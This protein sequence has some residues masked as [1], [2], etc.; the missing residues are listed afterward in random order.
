MRLI[1]H[2]LRAEGRSS[3]TAYLLDPEISYGV[4]KK[5][6]CVIVCPGGG[7]CIR[8][9]KE[10]EPIAARLLGAGYHAVVL[11]YPVLFAARPSTPG[12]QPQIDEGVA[13]PIQ[14][15]DLM[16]TMQWVHEHADR[17]EIDAD[18]IY[19][20]GFSAGAHLAGSLA[21]QWDDSQA[22]S[23]L[24]VPNPCELRPR[25]VVMCYPMVDARDVLF[26]DPETLPD[27][28]RW[29]LPYFLRAMTGSDVPDEAA[30]DRLDL[31][32]HVRA[33]MPRLFLWGTGEDELVSPQSL[34]RF[35]AR[36]SQLGVSV[37]FHLFSQGPHG[38]ALAEQA[39]AAVP[40]DAREDVAA[41]V[42][43]MLRWLDQDRS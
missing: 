21:E 18:R 7:Y 8:A 43:L 4:T 32:A 31:I 16:R 25:G 24:D 5:R 20:M 39:S 11:R 19:V 9:T 29:Q 40:G 13:Y 22:L 33:D 12:E 41:W 23:E 14:V 37:E 30:L 1:E 6:P 3:F 42:P 28:V 38:L 26:R 36:V 10:Q 15:V 17:Y 35:A 27:N 34:C 2:E